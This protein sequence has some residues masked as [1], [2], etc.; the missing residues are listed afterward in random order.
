MR[1][2]P[3]L[4][5]TIVASL[6]ASAEVAHAHG[7]AGNRYFDGT[8]TFDDPAVA[9]GGKRSG[10]SGSAVA[11]PRRLDAVGV[12]KTAP[13]AYGS[14][15]PADCVVNAARCHD[16]RQVSLIMIRQGFSLP[17]LPR[18]SRLGSGAAITIAQ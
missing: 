8:M 17:P 10:L 15:E 2:C 14:R 5:G 3:L 12:R 13:D 18:F 1:N 11:L 7:I 9:D 4:R 6:L 16:H